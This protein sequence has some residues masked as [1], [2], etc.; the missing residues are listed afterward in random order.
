MKILKT[1]KN[2]LV[3]VNKKTEDIKKHKAQELEQI[4]KS[5]EIS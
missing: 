1:L 3:S 2:I 4:E 5:Y